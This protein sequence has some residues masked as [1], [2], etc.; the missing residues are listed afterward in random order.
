MAQTTIDS[1]KSQQADI[2][3]IFETK[4]QMSSFSEM[5][6][7]VT[8]SVM[9]AQSPNTT[10]MLVK[11][12]TRFDSPACVD[13]FDEEFVIKNRTMSITAMCRNE[14]KLLKYRLEMELWGDVGEF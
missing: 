11:F 8:P 3:A 6:P 5:I 12:S 1:V 10:Y 2:M 14:K 4:Q 9:W 13:I 7:V